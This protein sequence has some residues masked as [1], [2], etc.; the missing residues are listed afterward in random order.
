MQRFRNN[1]LWKANQ[2]RKRQCWALQTK[3]G[4]QKLDD[5]FKRG[6]PQIL[7]KRPSFFLVFD[8]FCFGLFFV[9]FCFSFLISNESQK[10]KTPVIILLGWL[11]P[12]C[13]CY[14]SCV[15]IL[16]HWFRKHF[17]DFFSFPLLWLICGWRSGKSIATSSINEK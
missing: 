15:F 3:E 14:T 11:T 12:H 16:T 6:M 4:C 9:C 8:L 13:L 10:K 17:R 2:K 5:G 1:E 7:A